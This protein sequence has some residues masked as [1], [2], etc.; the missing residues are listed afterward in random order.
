MGGKERPDLGLDRLHQ[1]PPGAIPQHGQ[2]RVVGDA[3]SWSRQGNNAILV[4]GVSS[5][6]TST[7]T[8]DT[9]PPTPAT[10]FGYSS[11]SGEVDRSGKISRFGDA[12]TRT[13][14]FEAAGA[15][16]SRVARWSALKAWG[17]RLARRIGGKKARVALARK[18]AVLMH[19]VWTDGTEFRWTEEAASA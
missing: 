12:L 3:R 7:I 17:V 18:L 13:Y 4:H 11:Q 5:R 19:R 14:L 2:Q 8:E 1:H 6:V 10:K 15:L 16:L 9:P